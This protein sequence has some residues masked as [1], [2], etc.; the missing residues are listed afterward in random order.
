M[1]NIQE[2]FEKEKLNFDPKNWEL[3]QNW[4]EKKQAFKDPIYEF[5]VRDK[6]LKID[7]HT[8]SLSHSKIPKVASPKYKSWGDILRWILSGEFPRSF[9]IH[10]GIVSF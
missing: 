7:T 1:K 2:V 10:F 8:E 5:K 6:V 4:D 9:P 3:I